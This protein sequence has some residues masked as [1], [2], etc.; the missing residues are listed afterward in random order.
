MCDTRRGLLV[1]SLGLFAAAATLRAD[2]L[3]TTTGKKFSGKLVAV[4]PKGV[5]FQTGEAKVQI[6]GQEVALVDLGNKVLAPATGTKYAEIELTDGS[7][8]RCS[9]Y[10][11]KGKTFEVELFSAPSAPEAPPAKP[12]PPAVKL[13][14][15]TVFTVLRGAE[16][17]KNRDA[18]REMLANRG[19]RDLYV[20]RQNDRLD[21]VPGTVLEGTEAGDKIV[22]ER[23]DGGRTEL[24]QSRATGGLVFNQV[25]P[26]EIA[27]TVCK[28]VDVFGNSW[29][30]RA[31][32]LGGG[33]VTVTTVTGITV[34]YESLSAVAKLDYAQGNITYLSDM[35]PQIT[36]PKF[37]DDELMRVAVL[38][39]KGLNREALK[40]DNKTLAKGLWVNAH[41]DELV[42][43]YNLNG[44]YKEFKATVGVPTPNTPTVTSQK[45][46]VKLIVEADGRTLFSDVI[47]PNEKPRSLT[48]DVK[49]SKQLRL[50]IE[51]PTLYD[52]TQLIL[53]EA[54]V[55]K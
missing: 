54:R 10:V 24:L 2:E 44:D 28:V 8:L 45:A 33:G 31:V 46:G 25:Q 55:Q 20:I 5:T 50:T 41:Y 19:K 34:R 38:R 7:V 40:L 4:D 15:N 32:E 37:Q 39:D 53:G 6:P 1:L 52:S 23:E 36:L 9:K 27:P 29:V 21:T 35:D 51:Q 43:T 18:W 16:D 13:P 12:T 30:A 14:M 11:L 3:T 42:L 49:G 47:R 22:F 48:I 17:Q 26:A